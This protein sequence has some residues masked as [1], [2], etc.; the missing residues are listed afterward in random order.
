MSVHKV[1]VYTSTYCPACTRVKHFLNE[2]GVDFEERNVDKDEKYAED[3]LNAGIRAVPVT[4][5][6][7]EKIVGFNQSALSK[8][9]AERP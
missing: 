8:V 6:G 7:A 1:I 4:V 3:L 5:V 2:Q 9:L